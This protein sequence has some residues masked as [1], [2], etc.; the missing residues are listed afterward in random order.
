MHCK[1][2]LMVH[3]MKVLELHMKVLMVHHMKV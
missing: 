3:H 2:V 1:M